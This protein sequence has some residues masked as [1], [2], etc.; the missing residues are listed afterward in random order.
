MEYLSKE[1]IEELKVELEYLQTTRRIE[2]AKRLKRAKELGDLS[3][4]AEYAEAR[5]EQR[6]VERRIYDIEQMLKDAVI[7]TKPKTHS[8]VQVGSTVS[9]E[10]NGTERVFAIVGS[11]EA[12]PDAGKISNESPIGK[13]FLEKKEGDKVSVKTPNGVR[14]YTITKIE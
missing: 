12:A 6:Q 11:N 14:V 5:D 1:R 2:V 10:C 8:S 7:I 9:A 3:E 13:A 4:N